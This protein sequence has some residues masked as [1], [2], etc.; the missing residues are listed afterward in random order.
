[1]TIKVTSK[2]YGSAINRAKCT[3]FHNK[4]KTPKLSNHSVKNIS[5]SEKVYSPKEFEMSKGIM[6][7]NLDA[8]VKANITNNVLLIDIEF[9]IFII[10]LL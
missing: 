6:K 1:M 7:R 10:G 9:G 4:R 8:I 2:T 3:R 5:K